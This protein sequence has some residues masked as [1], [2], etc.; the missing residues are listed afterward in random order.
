ML[1]KI[2]LFLAVILALTIGAH[3]L[4]FKAVVRLLI[5]NSAGL[6]ASLFVVLFL[7][8]LSF[9]A[10]FFLLRWQAT[11]LTVGF[12]M[13]SAVWTGVFINLLLA[14]LLSWLIISV[15]WLVGTYPNTRLIAAGCLTLAVL[16][17]A[18]GMW[19]A[20]HPGI[21]KLDIELENLPDHWKGKTVVQL[22][23][24]HLGHFYGQKFLKNLVRRVNSLNPEAIFITGDLFDASPRD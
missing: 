2:L 4:F 11:S 13:F 24:V 7:L 12:Y 23:D 3:L 15:T 8:S 1:L 16:F 5:I 10:S 19:N 6:K 21:K 20:F 9:M 22:S 14:A 17:S 18:S